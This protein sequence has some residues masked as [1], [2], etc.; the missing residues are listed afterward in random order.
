MPRS[1]ARSTR[2]ASEK[3]ASVNTAPRATTNQYRNV[4]SP[5]AVRDRGYAWAVEV[6]GG[7]RTKSTS[8]TTERMAVTTATQSTARMSLASRIISPMAASGPSTAPTVSS[9]CRSPYAAPRAADPLADPVHEARDE[10]QRHRPGKRKQRLRRCGERVAEHHQGLPAAEAIRQH[11]REH[12]DDRR[13]RL[14][15]ALDHADRQHARAENHGHEHREQAVDQ[16]GREVHAQRDEA[17]G[18]DGPWNFIH[19]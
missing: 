11:A 14:G 5:S 19:I 10:H 15:D 1:W 4:S 2:N 7:S 18:P 8:T 9:A 12:L 17:Q 6:A 3:R 13:G 16:L